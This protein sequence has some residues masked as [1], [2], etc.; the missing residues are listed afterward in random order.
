MVINKVGTVFSKACRLPG[1]S[2]PNQEE[3]KLFSIAI[4]ASSAV[5]FVPTA[6]NRATSSLHAEV[7][8]RSFNGV[9]AS[10]AAASVLGPVLPASAALSTQWSQVQIPFTDTLYDID[11]DTKD[12]VS[13]WR[14]FGG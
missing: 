8:R 11:F 12:H 13:W 3:M 6:L 1:Q 2:I 7:D 4:F 5:A 9:A 10:A 14:Y